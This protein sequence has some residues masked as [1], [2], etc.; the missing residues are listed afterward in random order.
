MEPHQLWVP[1]VFIV[2]LGAVLLLAL[3]LWFFDRKHFRNAV[4]QLSE[5]DGDGKWTGHHPLLRP[6]TAETQRAEG[7]VL[8]GTGLGF[9]ASS[10]VVALFG[11]S[12]DVLALPMAV[13][14][15]L[16]GAGAGKILASR[17]RSRAG[18]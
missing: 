12:G 4:L 1:I 15:V 17:L 11:L 9:A 8:I 18:E 10:G 3:L 7:I 6:Y 2:V 14:S 5:L 13:A 16:I